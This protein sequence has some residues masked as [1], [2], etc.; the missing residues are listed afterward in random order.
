LEA[1]AGMQHTSGWRNRSSRKGQWRAFL[2][3]ILFCICPES[4]RNHDERRAKKN[5]CNLRQQKGSQRCQVCW[6]GKSG[7]RSLCSLCTSEMT[8]L[9][10]IARRLLELGNESSLLCIYLCIYIQFL[11]YM[12]EIAI[13]KTL[14]FHLALN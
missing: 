12:L 2:S 6:A 9:M 4:Y 1:A 13:S 14:Y 5:L 3:L 7:P 11:C 8:Q 10:Y